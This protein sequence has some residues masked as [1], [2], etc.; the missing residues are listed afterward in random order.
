MLPRISVVTPSFNQAQFLEDTIQSVLAQNYPNLEYIMMDGGSTDGSV[1]II[2]RYEDRLATWV[3]MPDKGQYAAINQGMAQ[4]TGDIMAWL[5]SDDKYT[6]W[7]FHIAADVFSALPE[8]EWLTALNHLAWDAR[9][10]AVNVYRAVGFCRRAFL[11]G[12]NLPGRGW[13]ARSYIQQESTFWRRSLWER[14][15]GQI[16]TSYP[17]AA[18]FEL[19]ARFFQHAELYAVDAL[20]GGFRMHGDQKTVHQM[21]SYA[22][23]AKRIFEQY[24]GRPY[25]HFESLLRARLPKRV[26]VKLGLLYP[27]PICRY[28]QGSWTTKQVIA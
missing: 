10:L 26:A 13:P 16:D 7:A 1:D 6:P 2:R 8:V 28:V 21:D 9:G 19:W 20:L 3:S 15:G 18:D 4:S 14:A 5:N 25:S 27:R 12:E 24:N 11:R 22:Q 23:E 17:L